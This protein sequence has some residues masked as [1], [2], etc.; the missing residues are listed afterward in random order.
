MQRDEVASDGQAQAE[1]SV[2]VT[3][4]ERV[5]YLR[6]QRGRDAAAA[7][8][9]AYARV[10]AVTVEPGDDVAAGRR[11]PYWLRAAPPVPARGAAITGVPR[12]TDRVVSGSRP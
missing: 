9:H 6:E 4:T 7:V 10:A 3:A 5:E 11:E 1:P 12:V 8:D 2:P